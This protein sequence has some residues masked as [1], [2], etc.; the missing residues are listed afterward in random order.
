MCDYGNKQEDPLW[1]NPN[2]LHNMSYNCAIVFRCM[3]QLVQWCA[4]LK[5]HTLLKSHLGE[6]VNLINK[7]TPTTFPLW[8]QCL[9]FQQ[10]GTNFPFPFC[11][12]H[13]S[14]VKEEEVNS[15]HMGEVGK[16][17]QF[18][19]SFLK[20]FLFGFTN[21]FTFIFIHS[22]K[23]NKAKTLKKTIHKILLNL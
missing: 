23:T 3:H 10:S 15:T 8:W 9:Y 13:S 11:G 20:C 22:K 16:I 12:E 1:N 5:T 18:S 7:K 19:I 21:L 14:S 6:I 2:Y 4:V 17:L